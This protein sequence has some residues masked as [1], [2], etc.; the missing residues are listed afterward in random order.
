M[1]I[2]YFVVSTYLYRDRGR[3]L[4][5]YDDQYICNFENICGN[6]GCD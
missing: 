5:Q 1:V 2:K 6:V 4:M 3:I